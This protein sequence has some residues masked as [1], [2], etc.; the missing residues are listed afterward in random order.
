[1]NSQ[2]PTICTACE[3]Q[4]PLPPADVCSIIEACG[5]AGV[6]ILKYG[7]LYLNLGPPK[8][9]EEPLPNYPIL[10]VTAPLPLGPDH[11]KQNETALEMDE[12]EVK[13]ERLRMLMIEDPME[14]E[15]QLRDGELDDEPG[16]SE[17]SE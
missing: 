14:Y 16:E 8:P 10:P 2:K 11:V 17:Q 4:I 6:R 13:A 12:Q 5:K 15:R 9:K 3:K 1:M 7:N